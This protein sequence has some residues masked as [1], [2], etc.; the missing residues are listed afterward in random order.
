M[1]HQHGRPDHGVKDDVV[2][3][4]EMD[5]LGVGLKPVLLPGL[6]PALFLSPLFGGR[7][8]ADRGFEPDIDHLLLVTG[9]RHLDAPAQVAGHRA[10]AQPLL[11]PAAHIIEDVLLPLYL[12]RQPLLE[13]G[14]EFIEL[15]EEMPGLT[16]HRGAS[17]D[18]AVGMNE[19]GLLERAAACLA[20]IPAR[21]GTV[22][23]RAL[24]LNEAIGEETG[25]LFTVELLDG[26]LDQKAL[27]MD[28]LEKISRGAVLHRCRG[29]RK[30]VETHAE[31]GKGV[32]MVGPVFVD[33]LLGR[34]PRLFSGDGDGHAVLI[35]AADIDHIALFEAL[36][37]HIDV[38]RQI[39]PGEVA[40]MDRPVGVGQG[41]G[42]QQALVFLLLLLAH[43]DCSLFH[44][45][46]GAAGSAIGPARFGQ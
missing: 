40:E 6:G 29:A 30:V 2:L 26:A 36:V 15:E 28:D 33:D 24:A 44:D 25:A 42:H 17:A 39:S 31:P 1:P 3:A 38:R 45:M 10:L 46:D 20:L 22:A 9:H 7:D 43:V 35:G 16:Q 41:A 37:A 34:H 21:P 19:L 32:V 8:I 12:V 18:L 23:A 4:D 11:E 27:V 5:Q 13:Q 14:L